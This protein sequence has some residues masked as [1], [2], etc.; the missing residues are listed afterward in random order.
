MA[1]CAPFTPASRYPQTATCH[2]QTLRDQVLA[3]DGTRVLGLRSCGPIAVSTSI[4]SRFGLRVGGSST[5]RAVAIGRERRH[6]WRSP[7]LSLALP[8]LT[9]TE[10]TPPSFPRSG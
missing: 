10:L 5:G 4:I 1:P 9:G 3:G 7:S 2:G 6:H 8:A